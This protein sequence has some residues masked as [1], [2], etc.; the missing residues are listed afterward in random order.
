MFRV[1]DESAGDPLFQRLDRMRDRF[2]LRLTGQ[3]MNVFGHHDV[4]EYT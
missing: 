2:S 3:Q 1:P 4:A